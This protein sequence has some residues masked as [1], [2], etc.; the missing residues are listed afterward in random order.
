MKWLRRLFITVAL[1]AVAILAAAWF[2]ASSLIHPSN[3]V[4]NPPPA[5]LPCEV[6]SFHSGS[7]A[8]IKGWYLPL[9]GAHKAALLLHP[10]GGDRTSMNGYARFLRKAGY[11]CLMIDF[12]CH[13]ESTGDL[14]T[15]GWHESKDAISAVA[16][17][18]QKNPTAKVAVIGTSLG[19]ASALLAKG[20]LHADAIVAQSVYGDLRKAIWN[21]VDMRFGSS[22]ADH[23]SWLLTCQVPLRLG[24]NVDDVS[25]AKAAAFTTCPVLVIQ[26]TEDHHAHIEEGR[27]IY[28]PCP[29]PRKQWWTVKGAAHVDLLTFAPQEYPKRV[30]AF[31]DGVMK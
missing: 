26:G 23:F 4:V 8:E 14:R 30:L 16:W 11:A 22:A 9:E 31:L 19:G 21:R 24:L 29:D 12:R 15:F 17:L 28:E 20:D 5:D 18:R 7:G 25:P 10:S 13:G 3:H 6:V 27:A 2:T 1:L